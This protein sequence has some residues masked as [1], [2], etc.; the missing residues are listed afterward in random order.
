VKAYEVVRRLVSATLESMKGSKS[1]QNGDKKG[2]LT[3]LATIQ[4][5]SDSLKVDEVKESCSGK[6]H[7]LSECTDHTP[8]TKR[9]LHPNFSPHFHQ[10]NYH[11]H[12]HHGIWICHSASTSPILQRSCIFV[13]KCQ[14][15]GVLAKA[16]DGRQC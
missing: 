13:Q 4:T 8:A 3:L 11:H 10:I 9:F 6:G 5:I 12:H 7:V 14:E 1:I 15:C 16:A 2:K